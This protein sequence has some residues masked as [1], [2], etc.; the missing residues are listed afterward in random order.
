MIPTSIDGTD[1][2]GATID[3][4]DVTEI[5]VDGQTV[6]SAV[7]PRIYHLA[8]GTSSIFE[9]DPTTDT[10]VTKSATMPFSFSK[11][12]GAAVGTDIYVLDGPDIFKYDTEADSVSTM[13]A[14]T[15]NTGPIYSVCDSVGTDIFFIEDNSNVV[16]KFDTINDSVTTNIG[17]IPTDTKESSA[18]SI[19]DVLY[20]SSF[21][22]TKIEKFDTSTNTGSTVNN[23]PNGYRLGAV[24]AVGDSVYHLGGFDGSYADEIYEYDTIADTV[25]TKSSLPGANGRVDADSLNGKIYTMG[26]WD[27]SSARNE[28]FEFDPVSNTSTS[29]S[30]TLP[31]SL[32]FGT[33]VAVE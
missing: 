4:T 7:N 33:V 14:T 13:T 30:A 32:D 10:L 15:P 23:L 24:A 27:G 25:T 20:V 2:T 8:G 16:H 3:G 12:G 22:N 28:I 6:F 9:Y 19:G 5:T 17:T 26:G 18:A 29:K 1:I 31:S 21:N 11:A